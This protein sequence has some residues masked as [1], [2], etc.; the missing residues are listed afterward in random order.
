MAERRCDVE[1]VQDPGTLYSNLMDIIVRLAQHGLIHGDFN[2]FNLLINRESE[3]P[4]LIDFPQMVSTSHPNAEFYFNRDV[5]CIRTF[6][7]KR[8]RY[9]SVLYP[10]FQKDAN[11]EFSLDV[12]VAASGFS[13]KEQ[14]ELDE[15]CFC[16]PL[17]FL[18]AQGFADFKV[19]EGDVSQ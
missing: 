9:E 3:Q 12:K 10:V 5:D 17:C 11:R 14:K 13:K 18:E 6:F 8:F 2:E 4:Y 7:R 16:F 1:D 19:H 15:V